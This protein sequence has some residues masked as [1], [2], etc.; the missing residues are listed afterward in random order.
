MRTSKHITRAVMRKFPATLFVFGDNMV[1]KGF[2]GQAKEM[3]GE[4]NAVGIPT[5]DL[6]SNVEDAFFTDDDYDYAR[7]EIEKAFLKLFAHA[8]LGGDI[9]W[10]ADGIGTGLAQLEKRAPKI[11]NLIE[12][13]RLKLIEIAKKAQEHENLG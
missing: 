8:S 7:P 10:P 12:T 5:K 13:N 4:P 9:V 1:R 3:R 11:W 2:G 6:P